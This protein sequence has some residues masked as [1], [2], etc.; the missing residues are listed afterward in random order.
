MNGPR[1]T[2][3]QGMA[4]IGERGVFPLSDHPLRFNVLHASA[5]L[6]ASPDERICLAA[7]VGLA[8]SSLVLTH[9]TARTYS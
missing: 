1:M 4:M 5:E 6:L 2:A 3:M 7:A 8:L 9:C